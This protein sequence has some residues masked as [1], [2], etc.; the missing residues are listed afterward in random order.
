MKLTWE[1][2]G[3]GDA[4][5]GDLLGVIEEQDQKQLLRLAMI[6]SIKVYREGGLEA[7]VQLLH[8]GLGAVYCC[9]PDKPDKAADRA[10]FMPAVE[11][12]QVTATLITSKGIYAEGC[13]L[14]IDVAGREIK[15]RAGR[16][17]LD[18]PVFDRFEFSAE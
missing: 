6:R 14:I 11:E 7:G 10:L 8:G 13:H 9:L 17:V 3:A 12:E 5:V 18:T 15:A 2:G 1:G 16:L 4:R